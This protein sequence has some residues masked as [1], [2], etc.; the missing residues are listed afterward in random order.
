MRKLLLLAAVA[1]G[2]VCGSAGV[3]RAD[4]V[5]PPYPIPVPDIHR[6][7]GPKSSSVTWPCA[8]PPGWYTDTYRHAWFY[9]WYAYYNFSHGP[10]ANWMAGGGYAGYANCGPGGHFY[11]PGLAAP[12]G[13]AYAAPQHPGHAPAPAVPPATIVPK[14]ETPKV[15]GGTVSV[16]L[17]AD[18]RL[19]FNGVAAG[20][21][22]GVRTF[23]T[24]P[25]EP[26]QN[27]AYELTAEVT[28]DG[29]TER[30]TG[31]VIVRAGETARL[32]LAPGAVQAAG[33]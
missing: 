22:G 13:S 14:G 8:T 31:T 7:I 15:E 26:G 28:R 25:L 11:W 20:G 17:P 23:A 29:R 30:A 9:P 19:L 18:A 2:G 1:A 27:Y 21:G 24:P 6:L 16:T 4:G 33:K 10:Y 5:P 3:A 32:T 12:E